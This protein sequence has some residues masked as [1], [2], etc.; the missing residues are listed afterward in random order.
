M[1]DPKAWYKEGLFFCF[2]FQHECVV[3]DFISQTPIYFYGLDCNRIP[4]NVKQMVLA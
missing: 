4:I 1:S 2:I 3:W